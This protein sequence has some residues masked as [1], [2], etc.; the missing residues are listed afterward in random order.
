MQTADIL[1]SILVV[2]LIV[3]LFIFV[4]MNN[5]LAK[6]NRIL[7]KMLDTKDAT[8][9]NLE[10]QCTSTKDIV[11]HASISDTVMQYIAEGKSK[12]EISRE[13]DMPINKIE[14][15]IKFDKIKKG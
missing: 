15:I 1:I 7:K 8:I 9:A 11:N 4:A 6:E 14:L 10:A 3:I 5:K 2:L 13:L 12:E